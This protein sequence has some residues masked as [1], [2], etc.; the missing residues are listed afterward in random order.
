MH[1]YQQ[2]HMVGVD[3]SIYL[4]VDPVGRRV[5]GVFIVLKKAEMFVQLS[6]I[7]ISHFVNRLGGGVFAIL[8]CVLSYFL[9]K[10]MHEGV[11]PG[12][13]LEFAAFYMLISPCLHYKCA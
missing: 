9:L 13:S 10:L 6:F 11:S 12:G 8:W 5:S 2:H 3:L 4:I 1:K 7:N